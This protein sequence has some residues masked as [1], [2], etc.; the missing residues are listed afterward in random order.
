MQEPGSLIPALAL[1]YK[2]IKIKFCV[3][4][5]I[6][7]EKIQIKWPSNLGAKSKKMQ[8]QL[9]LEQ[10]IQFSEKFVLPFF[11]HVCNWSRV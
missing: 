10:Q 5:F 8:V 6:D 9:T 3:Q 1:N 4:T 7:Q 2:V 11:F